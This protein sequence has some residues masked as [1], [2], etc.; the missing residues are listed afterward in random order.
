MLLAPRAICGHLADYGHELTELERGST[1]TKLW[2]DVKR[3][4][5]RMPDLVCKK[6]GVRIESRAKTKAELFMSHST[7]DAERAW[8]YGMVDSDW[9]AFPVC[10]AVKEEPW[11][12]GSLSGD[13]SYWHER[14]WVRWKTLPWINY[15]PVRTFRQSSHART[16]TKGVTEG[17]ETS[18]SWDATFSTRQGVVKRVA[19]NSVTIRRQRDG[20]QYTWKINPQL[21]IFVSEGDQVEENQIIASTVTPLLSPDQLSC[22]GELPEGHIERLLS[23]L[24]RTQRF[25]GVKLA[26]IWQEDGYCDTIEGLCRNSEEDPYVRL[27]A[28]TYL[29]AVCRQDLPTL[30]RPFLESNDPQNKLE[31]II[32]LAD[33][34]TEEAV[35]LLTAILQDTSKDASQEYYLRSGASWALGRIGTPRAADAL[36]YAFSDMNLRLR[37]ESLEAVTLLGDVSIPILVDGLSHTNNDIS[38]GCAEALRQHQPITDDFVQTLINALSKPTP[39]QWVVWLVGNLPKEHFAASISSLQDRAPELHYAVSLMWSFVESWISKHW[40]LKPGKLASDNF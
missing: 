8:D 28:A 1:D 38:A 35:D 3:K 27:E 6:C 34:A 12:A 10:E 20:H 13:T 29:A 39:S 23:S 33:V 15:L 9:I 18:V 5:V 19:S 26:R 31:A 32:A 2:K 4:R 30:F 37:E 21:T 40:E 24:E 25:T 11:T 36:V 17:S 7:A 22:S 16:S 14:N